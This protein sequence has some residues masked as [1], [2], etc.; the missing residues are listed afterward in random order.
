LTVPTQQRTKDLW[1]EGARRLKERNGPTTSKKL[2]YSKINRRNDSNATK[3]GA[4]SADVLRR[5]ARRNH[6]RKNGL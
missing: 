4:I 3:K 5:K 1:T 6:Q 2:F